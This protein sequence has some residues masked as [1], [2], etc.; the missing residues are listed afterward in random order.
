MKII[1]WNVNSI[2]QRLPRALAL[3]HRH[4]PDALCLQETKV[5]DEAF[6][7]AELEAAGY[8]AAVFGQK[9]YNGVAL[10]ARD[11]PADVIRGFPGDP[12][13][14]EARA[15]AARVGGLALVDA[16]VV[17]GKD[18]GDPAYETKLRWLD[19]FGAWLRDAFDPGDALLVV[20]D[21]NIAPADPDIYD[22]DAW[23]G[24]NLASEPE[25]DRVRALLD[26]GLTDLGRRAAG[27]VPG[28]YTF[29]DYRSGAFHRGWGL[30]I[31][32]ALGTAP[33]A[34]RLVS[35]EVDREERK[36]S[37]GEGKPSDHAPV[38]VTLS[39]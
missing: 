31:D 33:V 25:R 19:A 20:G 3:L 35:V 5:T 30:R 10:V 15:I 18:V 38:I 9:S 28:P 2:R 26:W 27:D 39:D 16:Y 36:E 6:P 8:R 32:L 4:Q 12:V 7:H 21:F 1:S 11:E 23:R 24:R 29:W 13:P 22:P 17:N 34:A 37:S 14:G